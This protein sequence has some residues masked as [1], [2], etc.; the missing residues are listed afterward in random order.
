VTIDASVV[1]CTAEQ[2]HGRL[3]AGAPR[4]YASYAV[5]A[6]NRIGINPWNLQTGE[7]EIVAE[8]LRQVLR[9]PEE[10]P[11]VKREG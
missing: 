2:V 10:A 5:T 4:I 1:G 9:G 3:L 7:A 11:L 8:R 6:P